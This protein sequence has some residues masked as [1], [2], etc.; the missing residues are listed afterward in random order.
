MSDDGFNYLNPEDRR[1]PNESE[2]FGRVAVALEQKTKLSALEARGTLAIALK[3]AGFLS[4]DVGMDEL[5]QTVQ[6]VLPGE[7]RVRGVAE[8]EG[9]CSEIAAQLRAG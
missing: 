9:V 3:V 2:L 8:A 5:L 6:T 1:R 7:L 4:R